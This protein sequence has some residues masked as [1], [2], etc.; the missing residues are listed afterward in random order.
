MNNKTPKY[1]IKKLI[2][3]DNHELYKSFSKNILNNKLNNIEN[4]LIKYNSLFKILEKFILVI[5]EKSTETNE[6]YLL[7]LSDKLN[8][9]KFSNKLSEL[10]FEIKVLNKTKDNIKSELKIRELM[11]NGYS[12][13][14]ATESLSFININNPIP[15]PK[16]NNES[17]NKFMIQSYY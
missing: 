5:N 8:G 13:G 6:N 17:N 16:I 9:E 15:I 11:N 7:E 3:L 2:L 10:D 12:L 14:Q 4:K 1:N